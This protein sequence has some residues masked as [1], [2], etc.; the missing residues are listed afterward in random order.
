MRPPG[1]AVRWSLPLLRALFS[2]AQKSTDRAT[3]ASQK[4]KESFDMRVAQRRTFNLKSGKK[5]PSGMRVH[6]EDIAYASSYLDSPPSVSEGS[7]PSPSSIASESSSVAAIVPLATT[8]QPPKLPPSFVPPKQG[9]L[10]HAEH[11]V[12]EARK[13]LVAERKDLS[14]AIQGLGD[15][16]ADLA[17]KDDE[18]NKAYRDLGDNL[19]TP[20][21]RCMEDQL[22]N[23]LDEARDQMR[24]VGLAENRRN[25][26]R[27][28]LKD[29]EEDVVRMREGEE[30]EEE[31]EEEEGEEEEGEEEEEEEEQAVSEGV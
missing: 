12:R 17:K 31:G 18:L 16:F 8:H 1:P 7:T 10:A 27:R 11:S 30:E 24:L 29:K 21:V 5:T 28:D 6:V 15:T 3:T 13:A 26:C 9:P 14:A 25:V 4:M 22:R 19:I 20:E 2:L 23:V